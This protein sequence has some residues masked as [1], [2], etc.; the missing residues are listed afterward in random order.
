MLWIA[1]D[2]SH[3]FP[4]A[5]CCFTHMNSSTPSDTGNGP[6]QTM[7]DRQKGI[8]VIVFGVLC[9]SPDAALTRFLSEGG[10]SPWTIIFWKALFSTAIAAGFT[11]HEAGGAAALWESTVVGRRYYA[12]A[13]PVVAFILVSSH[14]TFPRLSIY[15]YYS[16]LFPN[17]QTNQSP[18]SIYIFPGH[19][20]PFLICLHINGQCIA[21]DITQ[22]IVVCRS[23]QVIPW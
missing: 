23:G 2:F 7:R 19:W 21:I 14:T 9:V 18:F 1:S 16:P 10:T 8:L 3:S 5:S 20:I 13:V 22:S 11:V 6:P 15:S 17:S 4:F 12:V